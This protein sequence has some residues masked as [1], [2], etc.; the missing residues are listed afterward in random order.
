MYVCTFSCTAVEYHKTVEN[1]KTHEDAI[2]D[3]LSKKLATLNTLSVSGCNITDKGTELITAFL[4]RSTL[5]KNFDMSYGNLNTVNATM[6]VRVLKTTTSVKS[7]KISNNSICD[8]VANDL[9]DF[10]YC[11]PLLAELDLSHNKISTGMLYIA[12]ALSKTNSIK[13]LDI[14]RNCITD[15]GIEDIVSAL[16]Q[17]LKLKELNMSH[18]LL[19]F[20]SIIKVAECLRQHQN[21]QNLNVSHNITS[22]HSECEF[23]VDIILS[24]NQSLVYLNVCGRSIR[25]RF[26][27]GYLFP[28]PVGELMSTRFPLQN[29]YLSRFS[30]FE[31]LT[32][33]NSNIILPNKVIEGKFIQATQESCPNLNQNIASYYVDHDGG[34]FY[35]Q[36][37]DF[38][39]VI[40]PGAVLQSECVEIKVT[41]SHF[42][43]YQFPDEYHPVSSFFWISSKHTFE[44]PVYL[45]MSHYAVIRNVD[46]INELC[47]LSTSDITKG[48]KLVMGEVLKGVYFDCEIR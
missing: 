3:F 5:L 41:A 22:F 23:L 28:P 10:I 46:D 40:P 44:I 20:T 6:I 32:F 11:S 33:K 9:A 13:S 16:A 47:V 2:V 29:L 26:A 4:A 38:A 8:E 37:H 30:L 15:D 7:F 35:N 21:L 42:G 34:T 48:G 12:T 1:K 45:I 39:I 27:D 25:P 43:P 19:T 36:D 31:M 24:T 14:S 17:C 18:N